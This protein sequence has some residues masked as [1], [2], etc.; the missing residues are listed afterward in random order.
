MTLLKLFI[1]RGNHLL[2]STFSLKSRANFQF[3]FYL[4]SQLQAGEKACP[5]GN[6]FLILFPG[7]SDS[8]VWLLGL[9]SLYLLLLAV[10]P[11][12]PLLKGWTLP[13]VT[14]DPIS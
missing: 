6:A 9:W 4:T 12:F 14:L 7:R 1:M 8:P 2:H 10:T 13:M 11:S 5:P 3:L